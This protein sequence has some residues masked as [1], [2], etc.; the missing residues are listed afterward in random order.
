MSRGITGFRNRPAT[1]CR[2]L[3]Y[4]GKG[5]TRTLKPHFWDPWFSGPGSVANRNPCHMGALS[6][7]A[8]RGRRR[9]GVRPSVPPVRG[10]TL[11]GTPFLYYADASTPMTLFRKIFGG[12]G[13]ART[14]RPSFPDHPVSS[15]AP[16]Q[17]GHPSK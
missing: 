4:G 11:S 13:G 1:N 9:I 16:Y 14:R 7:P 2:T 17:F 15:R 10:I 3:A 6:W 8:C 12:G 5:G